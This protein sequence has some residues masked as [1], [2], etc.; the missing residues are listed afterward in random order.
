VQ[1]EH[2][3]ALLLEAGIG[4]TADSADLIREMVL[5]AL[6]LGRQNLP[7]GD[8]KILNTTLKELRHAFSVFGRYRHVRKV[9]MFG[10][11][12]LSENTP[13]YRTTA[14]LAA[15]LAARGFMVI[16]GGAAGLM[17][18]GNEGAGR[19]MTFGANIILPFEQGANPI[20]E[21]DEKLVWFKYFFTR[22]LVFVKEADAI[23]L[24]PGG[25][26]TLDE[27]FE[28]LTLTQTGKN[29]PMPIV[30][31]DAPGGTYWRSWEKFVRG[32]LIERGLASPDDV[33][34]YRIC[35][36]VEQ[37]MTEITGFFRNY[38]SSRFVGERFVIRLTR[39]VPESLLAALDDEF[40]DIVV[41]GRIESS[42]PI[43]GEEAGVDVG[44]ARIVFHFD[45][46]HFARLRM[47]IDRLN[48]AY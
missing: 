1:D 4:P 30:L 39:P 40:R 44:L 38:H 19:A 8:L 15:R 13:E 48:S 18:A 41:S 9:A 23:V 16:T 10:S 5:S 6:R 3:D 36:D 25:F 37:A 34:L 32:A 2:L 33:A 45:R 11:A 12:R 46:R 26:G 14:D 20:L 35:D 43:D 42:G 31:V 21:G 28:A 17:H 22:K 47:L 29:R 7:R 24:M 27:G